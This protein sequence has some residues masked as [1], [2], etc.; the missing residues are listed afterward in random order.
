MENKK[1]WF[2]IPAFNE[3]KVIFDVVSEVVK[4]YQNVVVIDDFS[5]DQTG[6]LASKAGAIVLRHPVN[7]G[8]GASIQTGLNY[9]IMKQGEVYITFDGDGQHQISDVKKM[10]NVL[11]LD[12]PM[13][14]C[15]SRFMG[16]E[17]IGMSLRKKLILKMAVLFTRVVTQIPVTD[18][19]NGL[20]VINRAAAVKLNLRQNRMAHATEIIH[21]IKSNKIKY[22]EYPVKIIYTD[23]SI[24]KGQ[25]LKNIF[26]ILIDLFFGNLLK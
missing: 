15:G 26:N 2:I 13:I 22:K 14:V 11:A 25:K 5:T 7:L 18:A 23:Y 16:I 20:R 4:N 17:P 6:N 19:H 24:N 21:L 12:E 8:Q 9:A 10:I 1:I 3:E